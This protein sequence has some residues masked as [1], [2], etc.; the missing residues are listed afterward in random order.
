[1]T[2]N[3]QITD[4]NENLIGTTY[5]KRARGLIKNG[6]ATYV[7]DCK[8]RLLNTSAPTVVNQD[9]EE[10]NMSNVIQFDPRAFQLD[11][12]CESNVGTRMFV[13]NPEG[14]NFEVFEIGDWRWNWTQIK[15]SMQLEKN[16]D[17]IFRFEIIG[18]YNDTGDAVSQ[19]LI[20]FDD[21]FEDKY[22]YPLNQSIYKPV[23]SKKFCDSLVRVYEI[24]FNT[25][26]AETTNIMIIASHA[27]AK[28]SR[29]MDSEQYAEMQDFTYAEWWADKQAKIHENENFCTFEMDDFNPHGLDLNLSG[30]VMSRKTL[31]QL[32]ARVGDRGYSINLSGACINDD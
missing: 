29:A 13:T 2:K 5:P 31:D 20:Y 19:A 25:G 4:E 16:Q 22:V 15:S 27:V 32:L 7:S 14:V 12:K 26:D 30:S 28:I 23:I 8:I 6:R 1:M 10:K 18:G 9:T 17:Y 11:P 3:V 21:A 24:P